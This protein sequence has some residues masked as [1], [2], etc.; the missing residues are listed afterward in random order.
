LSGFEGEGDRTHC[1]CSYRDLGKEGRVGRFPLEQPAKIKELH[2]TEREAVLE[3][4][5]QREVYEQVLARRH[6]LHE[7]GSRS[8]APPGGLEV[9]REK[10]RA[11]GDPPMELNDRTGCR[12]EEAPGVVGL[13][14]V[15]EAGLLDQRDHPGPLVEHQQVDV[16]HGTM[17][18]GVVEALGERGPLER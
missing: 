4:R 14:Q 3:G 9:E 16:R 12:V 11:G 5:V 10:P 15:D 1:P 8:A 2:K 13:S 18:R 17:G 6:P 7:A